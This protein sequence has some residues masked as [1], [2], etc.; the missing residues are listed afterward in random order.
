MEA[1]DKILDSKLSSEVEDYI[2]DELTLY[3][4]YLVLINE[5]DS[6]YRRNFLDIIKKNEILNNHEMEHEDTFLCELNLNIA[7][8]ECQK[9]SIDI[10]TQIILAG[11]P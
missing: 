9:T 4:N 6:K 2:N 7:L 11:K 1:L 10:V 8:E 3:R 5:L